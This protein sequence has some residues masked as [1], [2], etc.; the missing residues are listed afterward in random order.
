LATVIGTAGW[1]SCVLKLWLL[2]L[3]TG[4]DRCSS[5]FP[6]A[7]TW[8]S[9]WSRHLSLWYWHFSTPCFKHALACG[10]NYRLSGV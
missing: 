2:A 9:L 10:G 1:A 6:L 5:C 7:T 3:S 4:R 8:T